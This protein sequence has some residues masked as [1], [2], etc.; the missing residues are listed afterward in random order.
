MSHPTIQDKDFYIKQLSPLVGGTI[1]SIALDDVTDN[2][3]A[4]LGL[5]IRKDGANH[6][7]WLLSDDE[8]NAPGSFLIETKENI[9][10]PHNE[11]SPHPAPSP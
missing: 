5:H 2:F 1:T 3:Y 6:L 10:E 11:E 8:G 4:F 9:H 7:L